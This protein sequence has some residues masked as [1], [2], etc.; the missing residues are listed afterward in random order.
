[1]APGLREAMPINLLMS[2]QEVENAK[3]IAC[4]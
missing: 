1:M 3:N 2:A 4:F